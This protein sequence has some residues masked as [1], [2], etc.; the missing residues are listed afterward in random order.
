MASLF[1]NATS[2]DHS[3]VM[4]NDVRTITFKLMDGKNPLSSTGIIDHR[5][6]KGENRI[7]ATRDENFLWYVKYDKGAIPPALNQK[8]THFPRMIDDLTAYFNTRN[9]VIKQ[10]ED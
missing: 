5:L 10:I 2:K 9:V 7:Y 3:K 1:H 6:Y 4:Y 8:W